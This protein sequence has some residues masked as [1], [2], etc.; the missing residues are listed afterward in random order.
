MIVVIDAGV[1]I[2]LEHNKVLEEI[3]ETYFKGKRFVYITHR[4]N[5]YSV[6]PATYF[7]TCKIENLAGFAV[8]ATVPLARQNAEVEKLFIKIPFKIFVDLNEAVEWADQII[9]NESRSA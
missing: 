7:E 9:Q 5:S 6:D 4:L 2:T 1:H 8:V 3:A